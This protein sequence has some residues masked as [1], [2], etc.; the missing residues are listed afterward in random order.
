MHGGKE[1]P[2]ALV[3]ILYVVQH[4]LPEP[5][6]L[7]AR[8]SELARAWV[9]AGHEVEILAPHPNHPTGVVPARYRG[10]PLVREREASGVE[11]TRAWL[12]SAPNRGRLRRM[13]AFASAAASMAAFGAL[14]T[15][16]PDVVVGSSPQLLV[17]A[18]ASV[19]ARAHGRPWVFEVRD[20]WPECIEALGVFEHGSLPMHGLDRLVDAL[21]RSAARVV[22]VSPGF[23]EPLVRRGV[24]PDKIEWVTN[25]VDVSRFTPATPDPRARAEMGDGARFVVAYVGTHGMAHDLDTLLETANRMRHRDDIAFAFV[26]D[27]AERERLSQRARSL[28]LRNT[29]FLGARARDDVSRYYASADVCV[30]PLRP[31]PL[32]ARFVPSKIFEIMAMA[33]PVVVAVDGITRSLV[34]SAG[35]GLFAPPGDAAALERALL[36]LDASPDRRQAMGTRGRALVVERFARE[37]TARTYLDLLLDV[38]GRPSARRANGDALARAHRLELAGSPALG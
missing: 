30:A 6:A 7:P 38:S 9:R 13:T 36:E 25:G 31:S 12:L 33:R 22:I 2:S 18:A 1:Q 14:A 8:A 20:L 3:R 5:G 10:R 35:A 26:G 17:A 16:R 32:F 15:R 11:V 27:G 4:Y 24:A 29:R 34:E 23:R 28:G 37:A 21:Y 19:I